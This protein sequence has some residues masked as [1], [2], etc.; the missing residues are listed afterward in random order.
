MKT[1]E[2][3]KFPLIIKA[4]S[5]R[6]PVYR[7]ASRGRPLFQVSDYSGGRRRLRSFAD[8]GVARAE[9]ERI[10]NRL[11]AGEVVAA[12]LGAADRA[13][14]G[15][16][17]ELLRPT[18]VALEIACATF[19]EAHRLLGG[20]RVLEAAR[21]Y[22]RRHP[23]KL[24]KKPVDEA[25]NQYVEAKQADGVG[26]RYLDDI[27]S[28]L[29]ALTRTFDCELSAVTGDRVDEWLRGLQLGPQSRLNYLR[30]VATFLAFCEK[31][32]WLPRGWSADELGRVARPKVR[33]DRAIEIW[34]P[35]EAGR[36]LAAA[37][38]DFVPVLALCMFS[39]LRSAEAQ[40]LHW[41]DV[42]VAEGFVEIS[43]AKS[44]TGARR[45]APIPPNL[46]AWLAPCAGRTGPVWG[47]SHDVFYQ[48][49][50]ATAKAAGLI[51][52]ANA[53]RHS[54]CSYR[55]AAIGDAPRVA[56]ETGHSV[57]VLFRHYREL[58]R[59][60]EAARYFAIVPARLANSL[61]AKAKGV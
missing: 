60:G 20:N 32:G 4:G 46:A 41:E 28:R 7:T 51:W 61:P 45:L 25:V 18:G 47:G 6:V 27:R 39:G 40:R 50:E 38:P 8:L 5:V 34:T 22:A 48:T 57:A 15:R 37:S 19:S 3:G 17:L 26:D 10:A 44:K 31:R 56:L 29:G 43:G 30:V 52:K 53:C 14:L 12:G 16:A 55:L 42:H 21:D 13:S 58:V 24:P 2:S 9:A 49:Q 36:L 35:E 23:A 59:P 11:A 54:F 33:R 1:K